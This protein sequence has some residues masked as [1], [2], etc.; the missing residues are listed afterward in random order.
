MYGK[1]VT[2]TAYR[3]IARR[4]RIC[5]FFEFTEHRRAQWLPHFLRCFIIRFEAGQFQHTV[6]TCFAQRQ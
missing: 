5:I 1:V 6:H 2:A 4:A 3:G